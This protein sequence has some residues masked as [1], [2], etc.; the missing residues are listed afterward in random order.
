MTTQIK[1]TD[2]VL[3]ELADALASID[4]PWAEDYVEAIRALRDAASEVVE[5]CESSDKLM[6]MACDSATD[7]PLDFSSSKAAMNKARTENA[8][9]YVAIERLVN[10]LPKNINYGRE[11]S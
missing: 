10:L 11:V 8:K 4:H 2:T 3:H 5:S 9:M 7:R 6:K 1:L